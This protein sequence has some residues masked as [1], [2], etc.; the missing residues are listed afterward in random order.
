[1]VKKASDNPK[2]KRKTAAIDITEREHTEEAIRKSEEE[3]ALVLNNISEIIAYHDQNHIIQWANKA[4]L[5]ATG[6]SLDELKGRTC[7]RAWGLERVCSNCPVSE[8]IE[9]GEHCQA[10]L[11]PQNQEHWPA[12]QGSWLVLAD[13]VRDEDGNIIGAIEIASDI[14]DRKR[15]A[16]Q[17]EAL[18]KFPSENPDPVLRVSID[19]VVLFANRASEPLLEA[20]GCRLGQA[21]PP[22]W[23]T[24]V[25]DALASKQKREAEVVCDHQVFN[26]TFAPVADAGYLNLYARDITE[27]KRAEMELARHRD[28]LEEMVTMRTAELAISNKILDAINRVFRE[29]LKCETEEELGKTCLAV[30]EELTGSKFGILLELNPAGLLDTV[31][32]SN[33]GW[34]E[35]D[36]AV[37]DA[38]NAI[39]NME[40]RGIDRSTV[41]DGKSRIVNQDQ[42]ASHPD[43]C[44]VPVGHPEVTAFLGVPLKH[45]GK[46]VGMIGLG[47][48]E[49]GYA[50]TDQDAIEALAIA[51]VEAF[52][53]KR[54]EIALH[55]AREK[56][57]RKERLAAIGQVSGSI[58]HDLRNPLGSVRNAAYYLKRI[59]PGDEPEIVEYLGIINQEVTAADR[60][61]SNLLKIGRSPRT[62]K[63]DVDIAK[64]VGEAFD[65]IESAPGI[66]IR[67]SADPDPF[68]VRAD[69]DQIRQ[70]LDNLMSNAAQAMGGNGEIIIEATRDR[71]NDKIV[72]SDTGPGIAP[73]IRD[74]L[75]QPLV[76][77]KARG[78]GLGLT[79]CRQ[80]VER[81]GG[82]INVADV[83]SPGAALVIHLPRE[84]D[85]TSKGAEN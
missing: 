61:I 14:T 67:L 77:T 65:R 16:E 21:L 26:V 83:G 70:I 23:T 53:S 47:N 76:T 41:R 32:V 20:W 81:H 66:R 24:V 18:A 15:A 19:G 68:V 46:T 11:T 33:P 28:H 35:C 27:R 63:Q 31:A 30:A 8:A 43:R 22:E 1:M 38:I 50:P 40:I 78:T 72:F 62:V 37:A 12:D 36:M 39:K 79:I 51:V 52:R 80:I 29:A 3:K 49:G 55:E 82:T 60:I 4:Y 85:Q 54:G 75:F 7:Y 48:K 6:L 2:A 45:R 56:L 44:G 13:P 59:I 25:S 58:A 73:E 9:S 57:V 64:A 84:T 42:M 74:I 69:P 17:I 10:E 34:D 5:N 71:R